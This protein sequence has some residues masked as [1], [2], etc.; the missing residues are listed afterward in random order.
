VTRAWARL[1]AAVLVP[2]AA[3]LAAEGA[4]RLRSGNAPTD[5]ES[6]L[7]WVAGARPAF[8][9][10]PGGACRT[11]PELVRLSNPD[12]IF[13]ARPS[14]GTFRVVC[15]GD[16]TTAGWPYQPRGGY[17]E[18]LAPILTA[19]LPG[20]RFEVLNL[21]IHAWDGK[22][23]ETVFDQ[24]LGFAPNALVVRVGYDDYAHFLLRRP[25]GGAFA[26]AALKLRLPLLEHSAAFRMLARGIGPAPRLG[27][28]ARATTRLSDAEEKELVADHAERLRGFAARARAAGVPLVLLGL[29]HW[30][31]F[32]PEFAGT[33]ALALQA[34]ETTRVAR[35]L[36]LPFAPLSELPSA[37]FL[38]L[39]H[40][41]AEGERLVALDAAKTLAAAGLPEPASRWRWDR[42]PPRAALEKRLGLDDPD[43]RAH[44]ESRLALYFESAGLDARAAAHMTAAL[45]VAPNPDLIPEELRGQGNPGMAALYRKTFAEL[46]RKGRVPEPSNPINRAFAGL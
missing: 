4:A 35:E 29:P 14:S 16:S 32:N 31:G 25:R 43:Y 6:A 19:A 41:D 12:V 9:C 18:W 13:G 17:P 21:G 30:D 27:I 24:A 46:R 20:R 45:T 8:V 38:D 23:L 26:A 7:L 2:L 44:L 1:A 15:V 10:G 36:R 5:T 42:V 37:R 11:D 39:M 40:V 22:R 33:R 34:A 28:V 3:A